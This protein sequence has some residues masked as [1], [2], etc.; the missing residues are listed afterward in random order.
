MVELIGKSLGR[1]QVIEQLGIGG[2]ATVYKG[3]DTTLERYVAIKVIRTDQGRDKEFLERFRREAKSLAQLSHPNIV[4][5]LD[6]GEH[7]GIP[8]IV[9]EFI[10]GGALERTEDV[11]MPW[12]DAV[13]LL[14]PIA[15]ALEYAHK[16]HIIHRD[17]K[18]ANF[19]LSESGRP[20][21][22]DF[23]IAKILQPDT[24]VPKLTETGFGIGTP[25]YMAPE[26]G[27]G[28]VVDQRADI[29][30]LGVVFYELVTGRK[31]FAADTPLAIM[32]KQVHDP[33]PPPKTINPDLPDVVEQIILKTLSKDPEN[34]YQEMGGFAEALEKLAGGD[35]SIEVLT[36]AQTSHI[37][38]QGGET[39]AAEKKP[40]K[41]PA[42]HKPATIVAIV[43]ITVVTVCCLGSW[44]LY[45]FNICIP[46]GPWP[47]MP[48]CVT[49]IPAD[50][51]RLVCPPP[52]NWWLPPWCGG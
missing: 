52:G 29:Y 19:L 26:Q 34:R 9:M 22:S 51:N 21:L 44:A 16:H 25:D 8:Y 17:V 6:Y 39:A 35:V 41:K 43:V 50:Y 36:N 28:Q 49:D 30:S 5:V 38:I 40:Q 12:R 47:S 27:L 42:K 10:P 37:K 23:G 14:A 45:L 24:E 2:M 33:L 31:P 32:L 7:E 11:A 15:R 3:F 13:R 4:K 18:P 48:W 1:Y 46:P 20:M